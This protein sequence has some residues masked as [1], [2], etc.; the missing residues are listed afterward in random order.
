MTGPLLAA[1]PSPAAV[2]LIS[3]TAGAVVSLLV[4][5]GTQVAL[6][7]REDHARRYS[8]RR[9]ALT[10]AQDAAL[11]VRGRLGEYGTLSRAA[12]G[13]STPEQAAAE[14]RYL[15]ARALLEVTLSRVDDEKV[16]AAAL[17]WRDA[18]EVSFISSAE[19]SAATEQR[20]WQELNAAI[21]SAL[22][23]KDGVAPGPG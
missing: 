20:R 21:G 10:D 1:G 2:T 13:R 16:V 19:V 3:A 11:A 15:D 8:R 17:G 23:S 7:V 12:A 18:A 5:I 22:Q 14:R 4:A 9:A 6:S